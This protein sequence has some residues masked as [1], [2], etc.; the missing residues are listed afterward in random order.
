VFTVN[1]IGVYVGDM[2]ADIAKSQRR[3]ECIKVID[4][5]LATTT[6]ADH[7]AAMRLRR[8]VGDTVAH[9]VVLFDDVVF[10]V[11]PV[12]VSGGHI[13]VVLSHDASVRQ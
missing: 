7:I 8:I 11:I 5:T 1:G 3:R 2:L 13:L 4:S 10:Q 6:L 9:I 12:I